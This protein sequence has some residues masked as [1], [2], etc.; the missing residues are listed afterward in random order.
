MINPDKLEFEDILLSG[1]FIEI[2]AAEFYS[3]IANKL[4]N[5]LLKSNLIFLS[6]QE[7]SHKRILESLYFS[8]FG[9]NEIKKPKEII[10]LRCSKKNL[11][12]INIKD[13][14]TLLE[15]IN[16]AMRCEKSAETFYRYLELRYHRRWVKIYLN[17]LQIRN[18]HISFI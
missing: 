15:V 5:G 4:S 16:M 12:N 9:K 7:N 1:I 13:L 6:E 11:N 8:I 2:D 14:H 17:I 3:E 10:K 18:S